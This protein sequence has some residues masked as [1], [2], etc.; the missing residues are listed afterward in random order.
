MALR[1][2]LLVEP[3]CEDQV[4]LKTYRRIRANTPFFK[5]SENVP[6]DRGKL[7]MVTGDGM[8]LIMSDRIR[9]TFYTRYAR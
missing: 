6:A 7:A 2:L 9:G 1:H 3:F 4:P 5:T 8:P